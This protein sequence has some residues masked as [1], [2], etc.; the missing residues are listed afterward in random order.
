MTQIVFLSRR[1]YMLN[2]FIINIGQ[3]EIATNIKYLRDKNTIGN[4]L[5]QPT[6]SPYETK[7]TL[8]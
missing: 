6:F 7:K 2:S 8:F 1:D 5:I 3:I 4:I